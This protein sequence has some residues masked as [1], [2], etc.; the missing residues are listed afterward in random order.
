MTLTA[1]EVEVL[2]LL[3]QG[4]TYS[5]AG[6]KLDVSPHTVQTHIKNIY[7][8]LQVHSAR[9]AIWRAMQL[10]LLAMFPG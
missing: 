7:S 10:K 3:A 5:E 8:K 4:C 6:R 1:R 9:A 2:S